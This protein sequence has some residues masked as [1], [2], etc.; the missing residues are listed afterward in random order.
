M[1]TIKVDEEIVLKPISISSALTIFNSIQSSREH[2]RPWLPFVDQTQSVNDTREFI[3][4]VIYSKSSKKDVIFEIWHLDQFTGLIALKEIDYANLK[5]EIGY[6]LDKNKTG[7]GIMIRSCKALI[8]YT[9]DELKLNRIAIKV[10]I[11][12]EKSNAIPLA[13]NF[14]LEGVERQG[15]LVSGQ[16][17]DLVVFSMLK[18]DWGN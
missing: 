17:R 3:R 5:T 4:S 13:L 10:A 8:N 16:P 18:K 6:W 7:Q 9:F 2:L 1:K 12:N 11:G 14:Y 15:E